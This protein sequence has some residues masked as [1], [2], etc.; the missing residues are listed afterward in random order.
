MNENRKGLVELF[1]F[2]REQHMSYFL[3][4][5]RDRLTR[6][7]YRY[8]IDYLLLNG[9]EVSVKEEGKNE[10]LRDDDL[11]KELI[12]DLIAIIYPFLG[13]YY[14][15]RSAKFREIRNCVK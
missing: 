8:I 11:N 15:C 12:E 2:T 3:I 14:G 6:F 13:K 4:E 9:V 7:G 5:F 10:G 1:R